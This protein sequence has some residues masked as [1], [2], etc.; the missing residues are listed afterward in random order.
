MA[1]PNT[2]LDARQRND[3]SLWRDIVAASKYGIYRLRTRLGTRGLMLMAGAII[4]AGLALK[5]SWLVAI[6]VAPLL[7]TVLPCVAMCALGFCM[8]KGDKPHGNQAATDDPHPERSSLPASNRP[9][10]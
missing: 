2:P 8:M 3:S 6:G 9:D 5:W 7:L 10:Q 4:A 1:I